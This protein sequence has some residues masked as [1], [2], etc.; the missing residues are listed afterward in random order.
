[1]L[2]TEE[3][4]ALTK[5]GP[6]TPMGV[7]LRQ[8]WTPFLPSRDLLE[9]D[10]PPKR[11]RLMG[12]DLVAFRDSNGDVGLVDENCPHRGASLFFGR[13]EFCGLACNY[14]GW[15]YDV[16]GAC[17]DMPN[18]PAESNFKDKV[19]ITAYPVRDVNKML[20]TYM[21]PRETPPPF[22]Q[23]EVNTLP[24]DQVYEPHVM[25]EECN[26][27]QGLEG[28]LDSSHVYFIHGRIS[29][30]SPAVDGQIRGVW[31]NDRAPSLEVVSTRYGV[32][33]SALREINDQG[34]IHHR[35]N[36]Y[37]YPFFSMITIDTTINVRAW[38]PLDDEY[39]M[40]IHMSG[41]SVNEKTSPQVDAMM[42]N[43]FASAGG[44]VPETPDPRT[45][46][47]SFA[48]KSNNY[49]INYENQETSMMS[50][51][52]FLMNLQDRAMTETMG[53][54]YDRRREHLGTSDRMIIHVRKQLLAA[55]RAYQEDGSVPENVDDPNLVRVRPAGVILKEGVDWKEATKEARDS[56]AGLEM[57]F[58]PFFE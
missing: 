37:L 5:V 31:T 46:Y 57:A 42:M 50:G 1:M 2:T 27:V 4:E 12:E 17:V 48:N 23:F 11:V 55:S 52:P 44:Y 58:V 24:F 18:E 38:V 13:N 10:G 6:G 53:V 29:S 41:K 43:G 45:R 19:R 34:D 39:H 8:F 36:Q 54:T 20:W 9:K 32:V 3:N 26:W 35:V 7:L 21:G 56:D 14:H 47:F 25:T 16:T 51:I 15:K 22:P 49:L 33:Y 40:L 28:D 30:D